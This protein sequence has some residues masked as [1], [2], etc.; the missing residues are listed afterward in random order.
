VYSRIAAEAGASVVAWDSDA[1][2]GDLNWQ[3]A[4]SANLQILPLVA[5][6]ARPT[7]AVGWR[8]TEN[9]SLLDRTRGRF[10]CV[11]MLGVLHHLLIGDQIPLA[12]ILDQVGEISTR[13][14]VLEWIPTGDRHFAELCQGR[15][16][17]S[18]HL[19]ED[20]LHETLSRRFCIRDRE[21]LANGRSL[22]LLEKTA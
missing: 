22:W 12:A 15:E 9:K 3:A 11:L 1:R 20:Y 13:W 16:E 4:D 17:L 19:S 5:D 6:F 18:A 14:A 21:Q 2:A 8:G 7:P 10:D